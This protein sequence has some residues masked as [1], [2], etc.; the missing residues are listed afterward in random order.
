[1]TQQ[2]VKLPRHIKDQIWTCGLSAYNSGK[3]KSV[4]VEERVFTV[5]SIWLGNKINSKQIHNLTT[6]SPFRKTENLPW[7]QSFFLALKH[8]FAHNPAA[9][10]MI[11]PARAFIGLQVVCKSLGNG[12]E[13]WQCKVPRKSLCYFQQHVVSS[14]VNYSGIIF[15]ILKKWTYLQSNKKFLQLF[16]SSISLSTSS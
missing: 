16:L 13:Q 3:T 9:R 2:R 10:G 1:M 8:P 7:P 5:A 4:T 14:A 11:K 6:L 12:R 15:Q